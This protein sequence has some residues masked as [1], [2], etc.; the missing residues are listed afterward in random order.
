VSARRTGW[1]WWSGAAALATTGYCRLPWDTELQRLVFTALGL[2][3]ALGIVTGIRLHR[4]ARPGL[5]YCFAAAQ[6]TTT[7]GNGI[8]AYYE[9][10]G[11]TLPDPSAADVFY[12]LAY[13]MLAV[14]LVMLLRS[15]HG[16]TTAGL[17]DAGMAT[18]SIG[19]AFWVFV[20]HPVAAGSA[21]SIGERVLGAAYR[22]GTS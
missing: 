12:N 15:R 11:A 8:V 21:A 18:T 17:I 3:C 13:P 2:I 16:R 14:G 5:W 6:F 19:L 7:I 4:P 1:R 20:L 9:R 22:A 10:H